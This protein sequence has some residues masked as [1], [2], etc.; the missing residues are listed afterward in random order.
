MSVMATTDNFYDDA[1][2]SLALNNVC[3]TITTP[4]GANTIGAAATETTGYYP[5]Y[6]AGAS[7]A[8]TTPADLT[9]DDGGQ[10][11]LQ[12]AAGNAGDATANIFTFRWECGTGSCGAGA[13]SIV[14]TPS[15]RY[16]T[17]ILLSLAGL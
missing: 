10:A 11:L 15:G 3:F 6:T 14:G 12:N 16:S 7:A 1:G 4:A 5:T 13:Q 17:S 8:G 9:D 2:T